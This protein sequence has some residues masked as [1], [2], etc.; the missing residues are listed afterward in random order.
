MD[1]TLKEAKKTFSALKKWFKDNP[2]RDD[3]ITDRGKVLRTNIEDDFRR[4]YYRGGK[5]LESKPKKKVDSSK[6]KPVKKLVKKKK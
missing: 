1:L 3:C 4:L 6:K 5:P 2:K